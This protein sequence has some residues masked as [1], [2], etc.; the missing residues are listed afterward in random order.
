MLIDKYYSYVKIIHK[1]LLCIII[2]GSSFGKS[3]LVNSIFE[4][5]FIFKCLKECAKIKIN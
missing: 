2:L 4:Q 1:V 3:V 5:M